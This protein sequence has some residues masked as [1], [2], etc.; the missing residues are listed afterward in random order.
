M[1][2]HHNPWTNKEV[3]ILKT[4][5]ADGMTDTQMSQ[6]LGRSRNAIQQKR[7]EYKLYRKKGGQPTLVQGKYTRA[8][9]GVREVSIL[10]GL[11]KWTRS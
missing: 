6:E 11:F 5:F 9:S 8:K 2:R 7:Q 10:W 3:K 1:N 4:R